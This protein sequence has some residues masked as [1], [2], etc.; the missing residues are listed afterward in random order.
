[1]DPATPAADPRRRRGRRRPPT[2]VLDADGRPGRAAAPVHRSRTRRTFASSTSEV[3][4]SEIET[5]ALGPGRIEPRELEQEMRSSFLDYAM[6]VIVS[7]ALPDVRDGLKPVHRRVLYSMWTAGNRAGPAVREVRA[8]RRRRDGQLPPARRHRDLRHARP[9]GAAVLAALPAR[10]R[11]GQLRLDRRRSAG[12]DALHRGAAR[13]ARDGAARARSTATPSTSA[14]TTTSR[15]ASRSSCRRGSRTCSSTARPASRSAWR[16][17]SRRTTSARSID[18]IVAMI[19][20][21]DVDVDELMQHV[22]GP[23]FPTGGD[24]RR[25]RRHPR[26]VPHGPRPHRHARPRAHRGAARR[27]ERRSSSPSFRTASARAATTA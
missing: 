16:R 8:H 4:M 10:R 9:H 7:R 18:A 21:P 20:K 5:G 11:A 3:T 19:D 1:M 13:A 27:Q 14:R 23:D 26:R 22:K 24:H 15:S 6:S 12:G 17:T 25:P 2:A